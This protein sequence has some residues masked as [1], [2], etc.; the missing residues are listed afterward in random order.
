MVTFDAAH[1]NAD[2]LRR[3][4]NSQC[5]LNQVAYDYMNRLVAQT[6]WDRRED[7]FPGLPTLILTGGKDT[8]VSDRVRQRCRDW[9]DRHP[10]VEFYNLKEAGHD[11]FNL[12]DREAGLEAFEIVY[13]FLADEHR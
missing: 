7:P 9:S 13:H 1:S 12:R 3:V 8:Q 4:E 5:E 10:H 6:D 11:V 2:L